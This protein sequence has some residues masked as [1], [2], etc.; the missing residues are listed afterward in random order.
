VPPRDR[1]ISF[2]GHFLWNF[3]DKVIIYL[4]GE[5]DLYSSG[6]RENFVERYNA[7]QKGFENPEY[8]GTYCSE[9]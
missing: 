6:L 9:A 5:A 7:M 4:F 1:P 3:L 2:K 8:K